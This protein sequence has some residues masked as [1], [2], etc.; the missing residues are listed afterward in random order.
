LKDKGFYFYI[1]INIPNSWKNEIPIIAGVIDCLRA[2]IKC[3]SVLVRYVLERIS[4]HTNNAPLILCQRVR[5]LGV[6]LYNLKV[7][8]KNRGIPHLSVN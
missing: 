7:R 4:H 5:G 2:C 6:F 3:F 8:C 1:F